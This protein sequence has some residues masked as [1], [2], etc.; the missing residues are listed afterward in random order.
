MH[1]REASTADLDEIRGVLDHEIEHGVAH[2]G[3]E[4]TDAAELAAS[5]AARR[6]PW[7]VAIGPD[8]LGF[9]RTSPHK[10]RGAYRHT[11]E[12]GIYIRPEARGQGVGRALYEAQIPAV[13]AAGVRTILAGIALPN[14]ASV[15]LHESFGFTPCGVFPEVGFKHG[16]WIDVGYWALCA[17][18]ATAVG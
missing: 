18:D 6:Q 4:P 14:P 13:R 12:L 16:Q 15:R 17:G 11:C 3:L 2:F 7:F 8:F 1:V 10:S 9:S 5:F